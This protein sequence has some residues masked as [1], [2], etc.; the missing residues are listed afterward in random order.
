MAFIIR[1]ELETFLSVSSDNKVLREETIN[2]FPMSHQN[3]KN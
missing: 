3:K 2:F 1:K